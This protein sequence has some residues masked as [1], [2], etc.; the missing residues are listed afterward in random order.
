MREYR[1]T[2]MNRAR[3]LPASLQQLKRLYILFAQPIS[4]RQHLV[5]GFPSSFRSCPPHGKIKAC[6]RCASDPS[7]SSYFSP[8]H[9]ALP[10][11]KA[12][13]PP[14]RALSAEAPTRSP[15]TTPHSPVPLSF[16]PCS[17][18]SRLP[19]RARPPAWMRGRM[20]HAFSRRR[21]F[22]TTLFPPKRKRSTPTLCSAPRFR[23]KRRGTPCSASRQ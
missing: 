11:H 13:F 1:F 4:R 22:R 10:R 9:T 2:R 20:C 15:A 7:A 3:L 12:P 16:P 17:F 8:L 23:R 5:A 6:R 19:S 14:S 21:S 18:R